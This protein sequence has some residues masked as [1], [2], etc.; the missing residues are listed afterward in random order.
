MPVVAVELFVVGIG[1][2]VKM[3]Q[4]ITDLESNSYG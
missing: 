1:D 2:A 3:P 4:A